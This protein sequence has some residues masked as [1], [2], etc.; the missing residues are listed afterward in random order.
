MVQPQAATM[1]PAAEPAPKATLFTIPQELRDLIYEYTFADD[2]VNIPETF[3]RS[4]SKPKHAALLATC[5]QIHREASPYYFKLTT[6]YIDQSKAST[7]WYGGLSFANRRKIRHLR[8][9]TP[10]ARD[11]VLAHDIFVH[12]AQEKAE[13]TMES[14]GLNAHYALCRTAQAFIAARCPLRTRF[15]FNA[16]GVPVG[17]AGCPI[18]IRLDMWDGKQKWSRWTESPLFEQCPPWKG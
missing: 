11:T 15:S 5:K 3:S 9:I 18:K 17:Q 7:A 2:H 16:V 6:F 14:A 12:S 1:P 8:C 13:R 10:Y 4:D